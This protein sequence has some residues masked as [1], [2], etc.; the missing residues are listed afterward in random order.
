MKTSG[1]SF[2]S[3]AFACAVVLCFIDAVASSKSTAPAK[4]AEK[5]PPYA[6]ALVDKSMTGSWDA[7]REFRRQVRKIFG[8]STISKFK[9]R[10]DSFQDWLE[11]DSGSTAKIICLVDGW[12][13]PAITRVDVRGSR[14][15]KTMRKTFEVKD[16]DW[17]T[18]LHD[19]RA[20]ADSMH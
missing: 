14:S 17:K 9:L 10:S 3:A 7:E 12:T 18:A 8:D 11:Q 16:G 20:Y 19:A 4:S 2:L 6:V 15:G 13:S 1:V 5:N